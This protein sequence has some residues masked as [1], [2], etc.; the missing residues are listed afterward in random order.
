MSFSVALTSIART[1]G[2]ITSDKNLP[3][4]LY[5]SKKRNQPH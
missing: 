2:D 5:K 1:A 3:G 4:Y